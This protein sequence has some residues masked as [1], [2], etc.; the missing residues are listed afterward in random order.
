MGCYTIS[1][2]SKFNILYFSDYESFHQFTD[3]EGLEWIGD[4][5]TPHVMI[6]KTFHFDTDIHLVYSRIST[7]EIISVN[8]IMNGIASVHYTSGINLFYMM[9]NIGIN[10]FELFNNL[11]FYFSIVDCSE[12]SNK[13]FPLDYIV[14]DLIKDLFTFHKKTEHA[15]VVL[16]LCLYQNQI[17]KNLRE[18]H[19]PTVAQDFTTISGHD[20]KMV[21]QSKDRG[22]YKELI[23]VYNR[24]KDNLFYWLDNVCYEYWILNQMIDDFSTAIADCCVVVGSNRLFAIHDITGFSRLFADIE[25][26]HIF[27]GKDKLPKLNKSARTNV[28]IF[29][30]ITGDT[31]ID[32]YLL[33]AFLY[34]CINDSVVLWDK[35]NDIFEIRFSISI[36]LFDKSTVTGFKLCSSTFTDNLLPYIRY[37]FAQAV[38]NKYSTVICYNDID[39]NAIEVIFGSNKEFNV[40][41]DEIFGRLKHGRVYSST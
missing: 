29:L 5:F 30:V 25:K 36:Y 41:A 9:S 22:I 40:G 16:W 4:E 20:Y 6:F 28:G 7:G 13:A 35:D 33:E 21:L 31:F 10:I 34:S 37:C 27:G 24:Y 18:R 12:F 32:H 23:D 3:V 19:K 39:I 17:R 14:G 26:Y 8:E 2:L 11:G 1:L 15:E 38:I